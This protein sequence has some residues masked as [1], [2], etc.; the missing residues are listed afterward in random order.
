M[1]NSLT[2]QV[3]KVFSFQ[4]L[5]TLLAAAENKN[6][7]LPIQ[8]GAT[9][10]LDCRVQYTKRPTSST[11]DPDTVLASTSTSVSDG[12]RQRG[13]KKKLFDY[14]NCC[15]LCA[16]LVTRRCIENGK[17]SYVRTLEFQDR[18]KEAIDNRRV[19]QEHISWNSE[20]QGRLSFAIDLPA[21]DALYHRSCC[22]AFL[23]GCSKPEKFVEENQPSKKQKRGPSQDSTRLNAFQDVAASLIND[24]DGVAKVS[25]LRE[26]MNKLLPTGYTA[27]GD[28]YMKR[29]LVNYFGKDN[30]GFVE[31]TGIVVVKSMC[32]D[33]LKKFH[34]GKKSQDHEEE[35]LRIVTA[36]SNLIHEELRCH[37]KSLANDSQ[38]PSFDGLDP[39]KMV[40]ELPTFLRVLLSRLLR[41][42][43]HR[44]LRIASIG[45]AIAQVCR[46]KTLQMTIPMAIGIQLHHSHACRELN[47]TMFRLGYTVSY[48]T[49]QNFERAA[50]ATTSDAL[51][52]P[53]PPGT[54]RQYIAD[55]VDWNSATLD[56]KGS[57]HVQGMM[58]AVT[59][60]LISGPCRISK[61]N[62]TSEELKKLISVNIKY[63][64]S[65]DIKIS[66]YLSGLK[67][68]SIS[69]S[70]T[71][72]HYLL[73]NRL[74]LLYHCAPLLS[75][76]E[77]MWS[78][79]MSLVFT[80][81][82][83]PGGKSSFNFLPMINL[84]STDMNCIY[85]TMLFIDN[86]AKKHGGRAVLTM[87]QP[88]YHKALMIA[89]AEDS[90]F[91]SMILRLG[92][93]H[94]IMCFMAAIGDTMENSGLKE[95][96]SV[97]YAEGS[98]AH[99]LNGWL[100]MIV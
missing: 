79:T 53:D 57:V 4:G 66:S 18:L 71:P 65:T 27:Y 70:K 2:L 96:I 54:I 36:A 72:N 3:L 13:P 97:S 34:A 21:S 22:T 38:Y 89:T 74:D 90:P 59:P 47:D 100:N 32:D 78:G 62:P 98:V 45:Q 49:V 26:E 44:Q 37:Q 7:Q 9:V 40:A 84:K 1:Y 58:S 64:S 24:H 86:D 82:N 20:V 42:K 77:Y 95:A 10:H 48:T 15:L 28:T 6:E 51:P 56:G 39:E 61:T 5:S 8:A 30:V 60:G 25:E 46:P 55:N 43:T 83:Y 14:K 12:L 76:P 67:F 92:G 69:H 29:Q 50:A 99:I 52:Q 75:Y 63:I 33:I 80:S 93:F 94:T 68:K 16:I 11:P 41:N 35:K 87:D 73:H 19:H 88:L 81:K 23:N 17:V 91:K 31:K 85:S